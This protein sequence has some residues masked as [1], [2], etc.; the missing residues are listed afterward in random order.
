[1]SFGIYNTKE[2][3]E[4]ATEEIQKAIAILRPA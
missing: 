4:R 2:D 3:I 1:M